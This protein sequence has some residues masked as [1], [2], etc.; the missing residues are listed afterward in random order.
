MDVG[1]IISIVISIVSLAWGIYVY[2]VH[3][4]KLKEQQTLINKYQI[5]KIDKE[6]EAEKRADIIAFVKNKK[7]DFTNSTGTLV[8]QNVGIAVAERVCLSPISD[9]DSSCISKVYYSKLGPNELQEQSLNWTIRTSREIDIIISWKD[10]SGEY[11]KP[12][13]LHL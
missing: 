12:C 2:V 5:N 9:R 8:V 3:D 6:L 1:T 11:N 4:K 13:T 10:L 7:D